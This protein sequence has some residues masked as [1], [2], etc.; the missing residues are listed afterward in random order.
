MPSTTGNPS[1]QDRATGFAGVAAVGL[2]LSCVLGGPAS[3]QAQ[4]FPTRPIRI[5]APYPPGGAT[6]LTARLFAEGFRRAWDQPAVVENRPGASGVIGAELASKAPADG[7]T[8]VLG[9]SSLHA[10]LPNLDE[11]MGQIQK[12]LT[13]IG[14]IGF[15]S[16][17]VVVPAS[18]PVN[19]IAELIAWVKVNPGKPYGSA[20][21]GTSQ[22]LFAEQFKAAAGIDIFH[23]PYKGSGPMVTDLVAG[24]VILAV[25]QGP[26]TMPLIK[27]GKIKA[28]AT[29]SLKRTRALPD[30]PTLSET[31]LPGF[32]AITWLSM[33][34]PA[35]IPRSAIVKLN[36]EMA[37]IIE[38]PEFREK[39]VAAGV[40]PE[41]STPEALAA[42]ERDDT[43][44]YG[45]LI[46]AANIR[47]E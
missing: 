19:T 38:N 6:D 15:S 39:L 1:K 34:G 26:A 24:R 17:Y 12:T 45:R 22:H 42:R 47:L 2:F 41:S 33:Y 9:S 23:V 43:E 18:L 40:E 37:R 28:L 3:A 7:Y 44:K 27:G 31:V 46:R 21:S 20:G 10:I 36:A 14:L 35:G 29:A 16:S 13:P 11:R 30:V 5:I 8:M 4:D 32:E 25:E